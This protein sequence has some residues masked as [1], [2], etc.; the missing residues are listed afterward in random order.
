VRTGYLGPAGTF[1]HQALLS[2]DQPGELVPL[3][4]TPAALAAVRAAEVDQALVPFENSVEGSVP[5]TL[6]GLADL[7]AAPL[8]VRR[9][10][11]LDVHFVLLVRPGTPLDDV[12]T[13]ATHPHAEAQ[14]RS[15][16]A[17]SLGRAEVVL[18]AS[19]STAARDVAAGLYDA[20][21]SAPAA[22]EVHGLSVAAEDIADTTGGVTRFVLVAPPS[23]PSPPTG[24]DRTTMVL[25]ERGDA[26]GALAQMLNEFGARG[27]NL[28]RLESRPTGAVLGDYCFHVDADG[29]VAEARVGETLTALRRVGHVRLLGSYP[30]A[31]GSPSAP[32]RPGNADADYADADAWL[33]AV[34]RGERV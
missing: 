21:V 28:T 5:P 13:V 29:H 23:P 18:A 19:T 31:D 25:Y 10:V 9:E 8:V 14:C 17:A 12:R 24:A 15:W 6:D 30:K 11:L 3:A 27:V 32:H 34:R 22:A 26:P 4:S 2:L 1:S 16:L 33:A 20:A 7:D